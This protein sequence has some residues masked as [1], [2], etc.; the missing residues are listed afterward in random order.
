M[1]DLV[2][3]LEALREGLGEGI[4][5][6]ALRVFP[7]MTT[8]GARSVYSQVIAGK[9]EFPRRR[10]AFAEE[11]AGKSLEE[12]RATPTPKLNYNRNSNRAIRPQKMRATKQPRKTPCVAKLAAS[13]TAT[14]PA[15]LALPVHKKEILGLKLCARRLHRM[16]QYAETAAA[17]K[18]VTLGELLFGG[19]QPVPKS[20]ILGLELDIDRLYRMTH[21]AEI[22]EAAGAPM[23]L[24]EL[25]LSTDAQRTALP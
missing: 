13:N 23:S 2:R 7:D 5:G 17:G 20:E 6:F 10:V 21:G 14:E 22:A 24:Q 19:T 12:V 1:N 25:L 9:R 16:I 4:P 8:D 18:A 15:T 3:R 11:F